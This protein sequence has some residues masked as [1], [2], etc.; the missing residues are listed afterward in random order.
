MSV[1]LQ[2]LKVGALTLPNRIIMAPLTRARSGA[3]RIP[4]DL[5]AEYYSQRATAGLILTEATSVTP[6]GVGYAN[7]P[8]IWSDEQVA[9]WKNITS[10]VVNCQWPLLL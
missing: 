5:M 7:T 9:G 3:G 4:N 1:L 10:A 2:S 8:G 6:M